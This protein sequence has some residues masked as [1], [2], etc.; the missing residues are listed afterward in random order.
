M[1]NREIE[2]WAHFGLCGYCG[3]HLHSFVVCPEWAAYE[4]NDP[5]AMSGISATKREALKEDIRR[6][7]MEED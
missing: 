6:D 4:R 5:R 1:T 2:A 3:S 7:R